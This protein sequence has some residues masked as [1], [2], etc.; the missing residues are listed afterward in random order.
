LA[1][2]AHRDERHLGRLIRILVGVRFPLAE[3]GIL[4]AIG[5]GGY[6]LFK[7]YKLT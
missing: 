6:Q 3:F 1:G 2:R 4:G 5:T 7:K